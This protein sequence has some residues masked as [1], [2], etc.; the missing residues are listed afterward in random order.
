M[1]TRCSCVRSGDIPTARGVLYVERWLKA[2][3]QREDG[4]IEPRDAGTP[5]GGVISP[6]LANLFLHYAFDMWIARDVACR[7]VR[8]V[9]R[10]CH[11]SLPDT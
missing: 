7:S 8:A 3:M 4:V 5:Q 9:C 2:P 1:T 10:R 11:L 6:L